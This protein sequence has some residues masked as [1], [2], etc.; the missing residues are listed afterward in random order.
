MSNEQKPN[1]SSMRASEEFQEK[2]RLLRL[3]G[4]REQ[5]EKRMKEY[6]ERKTSPWRARNN[7]LSIYYTD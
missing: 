5:Y 6:R 7:P 3:K 4:M 2:M 1:G